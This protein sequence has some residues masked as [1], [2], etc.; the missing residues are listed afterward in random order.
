M[1]YREHQKRC[2][3][4]LLVSIKYL[5]V[6]FSM[7]ALLSLSTFSSPCKIFPVVHYSDQCSDQYVRLNSK[8][9]AKLCINWFCTWKKHTLSGKKKSGKN[10]VTS[11]KLVTFPRL[12]FQIRHFSRP[13]FKIKRTFMSRT[14]FFPEK[15]CS[16]PWNWVLQIHS[17]V[18]ITK[19]K[20]FVQVNFPRL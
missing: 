11:E 5:I 10:L 16:L 13:I 7:F 9:L 6:V 8:F 18:D 19:Q 20:V 17:F 4:N 2:A 12:I 15:S 1:T 3:S 14:A